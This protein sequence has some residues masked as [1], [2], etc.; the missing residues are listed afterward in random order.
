MKIRRKILNG[1]KIYWGKGSYE[2]VEALNKEKDFETALNTLAQIRKTRR[3]FFG[4]SEP[5]R[6]DRSVFGKRKAG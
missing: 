6:L 3:A 1:R 5:S 4:V 2:E